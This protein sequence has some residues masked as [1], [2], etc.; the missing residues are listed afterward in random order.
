MTPDELTKKI[1]QLDHELMRPMFVRRMA[2]G[3]LRAR[4]TATD[5]YQLRAA[6]TKVKNAD[7]E[8]LKIITQ[9]VDSLT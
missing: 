6:Q 8:I 3:R 2:V 7:Q 1:D 4:Y 5:E 9:W